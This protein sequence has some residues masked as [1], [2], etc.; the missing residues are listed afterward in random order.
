MLA[1]RPLAFADAGAGHRLPPR[2][3]GRLGPW[4]LHVRANRRDLGAVT[5]HRFSLWNPPPG[6][7]DRDPLRGITSLVDM[8]VTAD[9]IREAMARAH[10]RSSAFRTP[11]TRKH[12]DQ[13]LD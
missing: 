3:R 9:D 2:E 10:D 4:R 12:L 6:W 11:V 7:Q 13:I 1:L 8:S 5:G